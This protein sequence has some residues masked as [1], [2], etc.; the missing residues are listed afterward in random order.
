MSDSNTRPSRFVNYRYF[1][2]HT[3]Y[4]PKIALKVL[5]DHDDK[6]IEFS[7]AV[8]NEHDNFS[9]KFAR[10]LLTKR[11][12]NGD[13][14]CGAYDP[15]ETLIQN[16]ERITIEKIHQ[17]EEQLALAKEN[18]D[19]SVEATPEIKKDIHNLH[20]LE[21]SFAEVKSWKITELMLLDAVQ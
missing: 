4:S 21:D 14:L 6:T 2:P 11:M 1:K 12:D 15:K 7:H 20:L 3:H 17:Y 8:C 19:S 5:V 16:A 13:T 9:R 10:E 18:F